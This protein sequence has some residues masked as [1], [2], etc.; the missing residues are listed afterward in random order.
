MDAKEG[1]A[2][3]LETVEPKRSGG[4]QPPGCPEGGQS[5]ATGRERGGVT[6]SGWESPPAR[7]TVRAA[8]AKGIGA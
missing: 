8:A 1:A 3:P 4:S 5:P 7:C 2:L 6:S